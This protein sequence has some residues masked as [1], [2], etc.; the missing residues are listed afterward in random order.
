MKT[1][2]Q[3]EIERQRMKMRDLGEEVKMQIDSGEPLM[4][5]NACQA[6]VQ[7]KAIKMELEAML[8]ASEQELKKAYCSG[9]INTFYTEDGEKDCEYN[10]DDWFRN[11]F[12]EG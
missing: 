7:A 2:L 6:L 3:Q 9:S 12:G 5:L 10:D 4:A 11:E 1:V 8:P